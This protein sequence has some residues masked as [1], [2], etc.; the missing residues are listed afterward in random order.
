[1]IVKCRTAFPHLFKPRKPV[2]PQDTPKYEITLMLNKESEED[3][4]L[5]KKLREIAKEKIDETWPGEKKPKLKSPFKDGDAEDAYEPFAGHVTIAC[6]T[7]NPPGVL[8]RDKS[9]IT[10]DGIIRSGDYCFVDINVSSFNLDMSKGVTVY[11]NNVMF[12]EKGEK[13]GG[14]AQRAEDAFAEIEA[15][16]ASSGGTVDDG[17]LDDAF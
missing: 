3:M 17:F 9:K 8:N 12:A 15:M 10:E 6:R 16:E 7:A 5:L 14:G 11:F 2:N 13:V 1:M 4:A